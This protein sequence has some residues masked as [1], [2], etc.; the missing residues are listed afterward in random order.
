MT[1]C[2]ANNPYEQDHIAHYKRKLLD[3]Y[4]I[5]FKS[6]FSFVSIAAQSASESVTYVRGNGKK[7]IRA[8]SH[9]QIYALRYPQAGL[10]PGNVSRRCFTTLFAFCHGPRKNHKHS[11][12]RHYINIGPAGHGHSLCRKSDDHFMHPLASLSP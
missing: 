1:R 8:L 12:L 3:R 9:G 11:T 10:F 4:H 2:S 5:L 7:Y 6:V